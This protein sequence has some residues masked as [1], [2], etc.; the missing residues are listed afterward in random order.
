VR[1]N[2]VELFGVGRHRGEVL[3]N[4]GHGLTVVYGQNEAGKSTLLAGLRGVLFGKVISGEPGLLLDKGAEGRLVVAGSDGQTYLL[5]RTL[6]RK[7][8]LKVTCP[9][10]EVV[11]GQDVLRTLLPEFKTVEDIIYQSVFTFQLAELN[12]F[13]QSDPV[14]QSR[15]YTVGMMGQQSPLQMET[16]LQGLAKEIFNAHGRARNPK[17]VQCLL[18]IDE[19]RQAVYNRQDTPYAYEQVQ[20]RLSACR[21]RF[22]QLER[23]LAELQKQR[24]QVSKDLAGLPLHQEIVRIRERIRESFPETAVTD[25]QES[26]HIHDGLPMLRTLYGAASGAQEQVRQLREKDV[27]IATL[28]DSLT[29]MRSQMS[30]FWSDD[31]GESISLG[32]QVMEEAHAAQSELETLMRDAEGIGRTLA[33]DRLSLQQ[34]A[35]TMAVDGLQPDTATEV[36]FQQ[37]ALCEQQE[38]A[39]ADDEERLREISRHLEAIQSLK[40]EYDALNGALNLDERSSRR[41]PQITWLLGGLAGASILVAGVEGMKVGFPASMPL[42]I[43]G[44]LLACMVFYS[45]KL[46]SGKRASQR[47][48]EQFTKQSY[49]LSAQ[50]RSLEEIVETHAKSMTCVFLDL[51]QDDPVLRA[52]RLLRQLRGENQQQLERVH[53]RQQWVSDIYELQSHVQR[54]EVELTHLNVQQEAVREQWRQCLHAAGVSDGHVSPTAFLKEAEVVLRARIDLKLVRKKEAEKRQLRDSITAYLHAVEE[55]LQS[56]EPAGVWSGEVAS[57]TVRNADT[58]IPSSI[59]AWSLR[60]EQ[61]IASAEQRERE[62][63]DWTSR[64]RDC[65]S[66]VSG[67]YGDRE[68]YEERTLALDETSEEILAEQLEQC[69]EDD[70]VLREESLLMAKE[71]GQLERKLR[72]WQDGASTL[73]LEWR[74]SALKTERAA[75]ARRWATYT[76]AAALIREARETFEWNHRPESLV[77]AGELFRRVTDERYTGFRVRASEKG[78]AHLVSLDRQGREW[79]VAHLSRGTREQVYLALRLAVIHD[80]QTRGIQLPV[81]LDDVMVNFDEGRLHT[82]LKVLQ[83]SALDTQFIYLTCQKDVAS[84]AT[85]HGVNLVTLT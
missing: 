80:Y 32:S 15:I 68:R 74:L 78:V 71:M 84:Y 58:D 48:Q 24:A 39:I 82:F 60:L 59:A 9:N 81:V 4:L 12:D 6:G 72:E 30:P 38:G 28:Q 63:A 70:A 31:E 34:R 83:E 54:A 44:V 35:E 10:G 69:A 49:A 73:E 67:L 1:L 85:N 26:G 2:S 55:A 7:S 5:E 13:A 62:L 8:P 77:Y 57:S 66:E 53:T 45:G 50:I 11:A 36:L 51:Q 75:L 14:I 64:L 79:D 23:A 16:V 29:G 20:Q 47:G 65:T 56:I 37:Q 61:V 33:R 76:M 22:A 19:L 17:L 27:E 40:I 43:V 21:E 18:E 46:S 25:V 52:R 42:A 41:R 3:S